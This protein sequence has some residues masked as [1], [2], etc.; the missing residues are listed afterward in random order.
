MAN[1][2]YQSSQWPDACPRWA[3][4]LMY[5]DMWRI[6]VQPADKAQNEQRHNDQGKETANC[7]F[8]LAQKE[9][10]FLNRSV[11][12]LVSAHEIIGKQKAD[13]ESHNKHCKNEPPGQRNHTNTSRADLQEQMQMCE[14]GAMEVQ[15]CTGEHNRENHQPA[16][17][18]KKPL[19]HRSS[20]LELLQ[21]GWFMLL[22]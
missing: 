7:N 17:T 12:A 13:Q 11:S 22:T 15:P 19:E 9:P 18:G 6:D 8:I 21:D 4:V 1:L 16:Q 2:S 14:Q 3:I 5:Q 20:F 10:R